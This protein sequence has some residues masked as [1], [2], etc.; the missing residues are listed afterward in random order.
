MQNQ[1]Q[2]RATTSSLYPNRLLPLTDINQYRHCPGDTSFTVDEC[3]SRNLSSTRLICSADRDRLCT[4]V[5][6]QSHELGFTGNLLCGSNE[7]RQPRSAR[8]ENAREIQ[9]TDIDTLDTEVVIQ[10]VYWFSKYAKRSSQLRREG[11]G[12]YSSTSRQC[13]QPALGGLGGPDSE[14]NSTI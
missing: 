14:Q 3:S 2:T 7:Q 11:S 1:R 6:L 5:S 10:S 8:Q 9:A 12:Y 13:K 4:A